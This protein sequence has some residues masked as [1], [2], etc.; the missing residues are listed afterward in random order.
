MC[1][2]LCGMRADD[3]SLPDNM[4]L[5]KAMVRTMAEKTSVPEKENAALKARSLDADAR[6][7]RLM[8]ILKAYTR[9]RFGRRSEKLGAAGDGAGEEAPQSV[10]FQETETGI[11]A[12]QAQT[13]H[14][15]E[16]GTATAQ[17]LPAPS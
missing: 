4:D 5:L 3:L 7:T 9:S 2:L 6:I 12:P 16:A 10:V 11:A 13:G 1:Y 15:R 14:G 17:G 8:Q